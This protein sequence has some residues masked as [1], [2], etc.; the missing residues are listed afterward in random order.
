MG[1]YN[2][3]EEEIREVR[4]ARTEDEASAEIGDLLFAAVNLA[5]W[6]DVD[7]ESA[8]REANVR[9]TKRFQLVEKHANLNKINLSNQSLDELE[10]MWAKAKEKLA[11]DSADAK[12]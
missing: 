1:V 3:I 2:K 8:L 4:E 7:A 11:N 6:L 9:F 12:V 10:K 5:R